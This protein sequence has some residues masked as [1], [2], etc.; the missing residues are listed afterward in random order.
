MT[1]FSLFFFFFFLFFW[2]RADELNHI[3]NGA[4]ERSLT[5]PSFF[6]YHFIKDL[7]AHHGHGLPLKNEQQKHTNNVSPCGAFTLYFASVCH[8]D[9]LWPTQQVVFSLYIFFYLDFDNRVNSF[10]QTQREL[11]RLRFKKVLYFLYC[12]HMLDCL[13]WL[14]FP[15]M[16]SVEVKTVP[17]LDCVCVCVCVCVGGDSDIVF[18]LSMVCGCFILIK[19]FPEEC[20]T[21]EAKYSFESRKSRLLYQS[22]N[23]LCPSGRCRKCRTVT[24]SRRRLSSAPMSDLIENEAP[25]GFFSSRHHVARAVFRFRCVVGAAEYNFKKRWIRERC[26]RNTALKKKRL[27]KVL[28]LF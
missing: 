24:R 5:P 11:F 20:N 7:S 23:I 10:I 19:E 26:R 4:L 21:E 15:S 18:N 2:R 25:V 13:Q 12:R 16:C 22:S 3:S 9:T 28:P 14:V 17:S 6:S 27:I 8:S 1:I